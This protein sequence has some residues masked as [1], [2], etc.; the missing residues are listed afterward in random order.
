MWRISSLLTFW[1]TVAISF[2]PCVAQLVPDSA[3]DR[4]LDTTIQQITPEVD[5]VTGGTRPSNGINLFHSFTDFNVSAGRGVYFETP[6]GVQNILARVTGT[7]RSNISG[8]LGTTGNAN[9][10]LLNP[11]GIIFNNT[12]RLDVRGSFAATTANEI[13]IGEIG[14]FSASNPQASVLLNI[15]PSALLSNQLGQSGSIELNQV[16]LS[17][18]LGQNLFLVGGAIRMDDGLILALDGRVELGGLIE[19]GVVTFNHDAIQTTLGFPNNVARSDVTITNNGLIGVSEN[20]SGSIEVHAR[21]FELSGGSGLFAG[22]FDGQ[23][24]EQPGK[25]TINATDTVTLKQQSSIGNSVDE[26][27]IGKGGDIE[28]NTG[29]LSILDG[30][31]VNTFHNGQG[32]SGNIIVNA[33]DRV[34]VSG[35]DL[36]GNSSSVLTVGLRGT[37]NA[38]DIRISAG[39][40]DLIDGGRLE[41][42]SNRPGIGG[43]IA[44]DIR[45]R[46]TLYGTSPVSQLSSGVFATLTQN[47]VGVAGDIK[48]TT[49]SLSITDGAVIQVNTYGSGDSGNVLIDARDSVVLEGFFSDGVDVLT[50]GISS[51]VVRSEAIGNGGTIQIAADSLTVKN[52]ADISAGTSG[53]G[54]GGK[55]L[56]NVR[57]QVTIDGQSQALIRRGDVNIPVLSSI[58]SLVLPEAIGNSGE[59]QITAGSVDILNGGGVFA[60]TSGQ[61]NGGNTIIRARDRVLLD[62]I[63][64]NRTN[65]SIRSGTLNFTSAGITFLGLGNA[66]NIE[67][68]AND[69]TISNGAFLSTVTEGQ[70]NAG[71]INLTVRNA[72]IVQGSNRT[73]LSSSS[74][75]LAAAGISSTGQGGSVQ[76]TAPQFSLLDSAIVFV[77]NAGQGNAGTLSVNAD[78][79][80]LDNQSVLSSASTF[81]NGGNIFLNAQDLIL[82]RRG[83]FITTSASGLLNSLNSGSGGNITINAKF[84]VSSGLENTNIIAN[85]FRGQGGNVTINAQGIFGFTPRSQSELV[86]IFGTTDLTNADFDLLPTN[87]IIAV[88]RENPTLSGRIQLNLLAVD[89]SQGLATLPTT[90]VDRT[91]QITQGCQSTVSANRS[92]FINTGRGGVPASPTDSLTSSSDFDRWITLNPSSMKSSHQAASPIPQIEQPSIVE[93]QGWI[94]NADGTIALVAEA[95]FQAMTPPCQ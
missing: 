52:G 8:I 58:S 45:D 59:I 83:S 29:S 13:A 56:I 40:L 67:I 24:T 30:S 15:Q 85:A 53:R 61:G 89:P 48:L 54:N 17:V 18:P 69:L 35:A 77:G 60:T 36:K 70:G 37:G 16:N 23:G 41:T 49:G 76:I 33:Q 6:T 5:L 39:T 21:N 80:N 7:N 82:L 66:G 84:L 94:R 91:T 26:N 1:G 51:D 4:S 44:L 92:S 79:I 93:A 90:V 32:D 28:I 86:K 68:E 73:D 64:N 88:S 57:D 2:Q 10:F 62:G 38:G 31:F 20:G 72:L 50:S 47:G 19:S 46:T 81:G 42:S 11:N 55:I 74:A 3:G 65:S 43:N 34:V 75:I 25:I 22:T 63:A 14:R 9:L 71:N 87:D 78:Q 95:P 27:L 12:A